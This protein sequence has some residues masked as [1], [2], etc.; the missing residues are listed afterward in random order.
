[1]PNQVFVSPGVYT[2]EK[3]LTF[4]TRQVGVTTLGMVGETT[5][6]PAFQPIFISNYGEFQSFF[7]GLNATKVKDTGAPLYELPYVAKSYLSQSNQLFVT[8]VLGFSGYYAGL[9]WGITID[10]ALDPSTVET[11]NTGTTYPVL[12]TYTATSAGTNVT[13][14]SQDS[15]IQS[16]IN[17]GSLTSSLAFLGGASTG[18]TANISATYL[19]T[20]SSFSGVSFDL[21]VTEKGTTGSDITGSTSGITVNYSGTSYSDVEN[22]LVALLRSRGSINS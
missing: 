16:L 4:V 22:Q 3:D 18:A 17:D 5:Q 21:F 10:A 6:G 12:I 13:L 11:T 15:L 14:V 8:R 2:S 9:A 7:G 1:M 20:G 19:K